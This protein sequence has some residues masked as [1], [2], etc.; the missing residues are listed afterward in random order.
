MADAD[1]LVIGAGFAGL[2]AANRA[3][4]IGLSV[5]VIEAAAEAA[6]NNSRIATG[7]LHVAFRHPGRTPAP[8]LESHLDAILG[9]G[10]STALRAVTAQNA[11]AVFQWLQAEGAEISEVDYGKGVLPILAPQRQFTA[12]LDWQDTGCERFLLRLRGNLE[13]RDGRLEFGR[14]ATSIT[15]Q[16]DRFVTMLAD[17][18]AIA[19][20]AILLADGGFQ[21]DANLVGRFLT[22]APGRIKLRAISGR[23]DGIRLAEALGADLV[24]MENFYGHLLSIDAL[25]RDDLWPYPNIDSV[26]TAGL[27]V[28]RAGH[29]VGAAG[30]NAI[31]ITNLV[32]RRADPLD[33]LALCDDVAWKGAVA[34]DFVPPNPVL[35]N[36]GATLYEAATLEALAELAGIDRDG[37]LATAAQA[38]TAAHPPL[39]VPPFRAV[40]VCAGVTST[41]GGLRV[42]AAGQVLDRDGAVLPGLYAAGSCLGG[43]EGG[44]RAGYSGGLMKAFIS[45]WLAGGAVGGAA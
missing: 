10:E 31:W 16:G 45:G 14:S 11:A 32:A 8:D 18:G 7:V 29:R 44:A 19:S 37:L 22:P 42:D 30:D 23:G 28:D 3:A 1:L 35:R 6:P 24:G 27:L 5:T 20:P 25:Q 34:R 4:A 39:G 33:C 13:R 43:Y 15:R 38:N 9:E 26:A 41:M 17:Q 36:L 40:P 12:G 2:A 21:A